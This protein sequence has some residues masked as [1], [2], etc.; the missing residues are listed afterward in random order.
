MTN[1]KILKNLYES[2]NR[3]M[4]LDFSNHLKIANELNVNSTNVYIK[5]LLENYMERIKDP[6]EYEGFDDEN[7]IKLHDCICYLVEKVKNFDIS[8]WELYEIPVDNTHCFFN[9][10]KNQAFDLI[11]EG[12]GHVEPYYIDQNGNQQIADTISDAITSFNPF[13]I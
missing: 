9:Q 6:D 4:I 2:I 1:E 12:L 5:E 8:G 10:T 13:Y 11:F 3:L 7:L